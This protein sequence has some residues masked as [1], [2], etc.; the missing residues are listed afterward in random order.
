MAC[1]LPGTQLAMHRS[2]PPTAQ[3][4]CAGCH[5]SRPP[6]GELGQAVPLEILA[7]RLAELVRV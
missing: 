6:R 1:D 7:E 3:T 4:P 5:V 2:T